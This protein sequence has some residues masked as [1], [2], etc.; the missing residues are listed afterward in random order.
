MKRLLAALAAAVLLSASARAVERH[1]YRF[2]V[3]PQQDLK[4]LAGLW[5]P[6]LSD[7]S[8]RS[9]VR[10][11]FVTAPSVQEFEEHFKAGDY[12]FVYI[13]PSVYALSGKDYQ[14]FARE[15]AKLHGILVVSRDS[16][17]RSLKDLKGARLAFPGPAAYAATQLNMRDLKAA[18]LDLEHDLFVTYVGSQDASYKAVAQGLADAAGGVQRTFDMLPPDL[19]ARLRVLHRTPSGTPHPFAAHRRVPQAAVEKVAAALASLAGDERGRAALKSLGMKKI[20]RARDSD[21]DELRDR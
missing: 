4:T 1:V 3:V 5:P 21:W 12:D 19:R 14:A 2:G 9:G 10:L 6:L 16:A 11:E 13:N 15:D 7:L 18:D 8:R 20:I 17:W